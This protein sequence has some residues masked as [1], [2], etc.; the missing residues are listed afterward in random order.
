MYMETWNARLS[1]VIDW[2]ENSTDESDDFEDS[3][4]I[5]QMMNRRAQKIGN[6]R[7]EYLKKM[8]ASVRAELKQYDDS[9][10]ITRSSLP[11]D[12]INTLGI[13]QNEAYQAHY[14]FFESSETLSLVH[15]RR[16]SGVTATYVD[17][18]AYAIH[19]TKTLYNQL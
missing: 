18:E 3:K 17:A 5:I 13:I 8:W 2:L 14:A 9:P 12:L 16:Q 1:I 4:Q 7:P 19:K 6:D 15:F 11:Q 10:I